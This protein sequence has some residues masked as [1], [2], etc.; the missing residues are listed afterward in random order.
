MPVSYLE[1]LLILWWRLEHMTI[2]TETFRVIN[3]FKISVYISNRNIVPH[4]SFR[5]QI[6]STRLSSF[7]EFQVTYVGKKWNLTLND[8]VGM[9]VFN[10][11]VVLLIKNEKSEYIL[12][13][14]GY[15]FQKSWQIS[16]LR[17]RIGSHQKDWKHGICFMFYAIS[18]ILHEF[19]I[20]AFFCLIYFMILL[21]NDLIALSF[22]N[23]KI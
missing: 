22:C 10:V 20:L 13:K 14:K 12:Q 17:V 8:F 16:I 21:I 2:L 4:K 11:G 3:E 18:D 15:T 1:C 9:L 6:Q 23:C 19:A 7:N 5:R